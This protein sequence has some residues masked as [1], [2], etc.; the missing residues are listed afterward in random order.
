MRQITELQEKIESDISHSKIT[1]EAFDLWKSNDVTI[2][3]M[4]C[5]KEMYL[6]KLTQQPIGDPMAVFTEQIARKTACDLIDQFL[7]WNPL[8]Q[9]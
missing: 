6:E 7:E 4:S 1:D 9:D 5:M 3:L 2:L 8:K